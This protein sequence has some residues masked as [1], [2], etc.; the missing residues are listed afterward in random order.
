MIDDIQP[1]NRKYPGIIFR[2]DRDCGDQLLNVE[3]YAV[4]A[5]EPATGVVVLDVALL[6]EQFEVR[7]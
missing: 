7:S 6:E 5:A 1:S 2:A 4:L 3:G